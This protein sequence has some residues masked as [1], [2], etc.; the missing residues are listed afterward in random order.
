[1]LH[2]ESKF[3]Q[4]SN[5]NQSGQPLFTWLEIYGGTLN[6]K[7]SCIQVKMSSIQNY[8]KIEQLISASLQLDK[9]VFFFFDLTW[10]S[11]FLDH[12]SNLYLLFT[13]IFKSIFIFDDISYYMVV[14]GITFEQINVHIFLKYTSYDVKKWFKV[15]IDIQ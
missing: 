15:E 2:P 4:L 3:Y 7:E 13:F 1:M 9:P 12:D 5:I 8:H 10:L 14:K 11:S 6:P